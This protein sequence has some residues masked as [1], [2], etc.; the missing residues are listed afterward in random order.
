MLRFSAADPTDRAGRAG[1]VVEAGEAMDRVAVLA[2]AWAAADLAA[3]AVLM[4]RAEAAGRAEVVARAAAVAPVG[5][6]DPAEVVVRAVAVDRA[7]A[8]DPSDTSLQKLR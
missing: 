2:E 8:A 5:P 6:A 3:Q 1:P 7:E 4:D